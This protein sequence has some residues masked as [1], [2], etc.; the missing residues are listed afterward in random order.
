MKAN[1]GAAGVDKLDI[2]AVEK[3]YRSLLYKLWNRMS[4]GSY[5]A[6]LIKKLE[7]PKN[8]VKMA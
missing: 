2:E 3:D 6:S 1:H 5:M 8:D 4:S 7:I